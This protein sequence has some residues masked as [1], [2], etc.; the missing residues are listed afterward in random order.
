[1]KFIYILLLPYFR[2]MTTSKIRCWI[3]KYPEMKTEGTIIFCT[4][5]RAIRL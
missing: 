5:R 2:V 1:M 4:S 3:E